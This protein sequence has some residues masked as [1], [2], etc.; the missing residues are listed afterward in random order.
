MR[1]NQV[2]TVVRRMKVP[3]ALFGWNFSLIKILHLF[4]DYLY[5]F[6]SLGGIGNH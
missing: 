4:D 2:T 5:R 6:A 3:P 1:L